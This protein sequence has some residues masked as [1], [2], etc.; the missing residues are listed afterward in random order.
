MPVYRI[1]ASADFT[2]PPN[3]KSSGAVNNRGSATRIG[4]SS[5]NLGNVAISRSQVATGSIV[6]DGAYTD[7][8]LNGTTISFRN[9]RPV[10]KRVTSS[11]AGQ[12]NTYLLSGADV[13]AQNRSIHKREA[14]KVS[15]VA[16]ATR[17]GHWDAYKGKYTANGS[18]T[19]SAFTVTANVP[20][21][22]LT[23]NDFIM[24][25]FTSGTATDG[26]FQ[27]SVVDVNNFTVTH[28]TSGTTSGNV[29]LM[30]P[31]YGVESVN[32][33]TAATPS[34]ASPGQLTYRTG[35][36]IPVTTNDYKAR[37]IW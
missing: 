30:G 7:P 6:V 10:A 37:T 14:Y 26:R 5:T 8:A 32:S 31:A 33:D 9:Q 27:V 36:K 12:S 11:L 4:A 17:N 21:H 23:T 2:L 35:S 22:G 16:T 28:G 13:P 20:R 19:R 15:R 3:V 34:Q 18:Y 24:L 1:S 25:D 29:V